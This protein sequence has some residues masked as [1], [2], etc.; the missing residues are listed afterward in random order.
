MELAQ[1][2][3]A[4]EAAAAYS[5]KFNSLEDDPD[6]RDLFTQISSSRCTALFRFETS[7]DAP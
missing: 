7:L 5:A 3:T 1:E 6:R 4:E 2:M